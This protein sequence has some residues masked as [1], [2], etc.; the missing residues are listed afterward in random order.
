MCLGSGKSF[1]DFYR[2]ADWNLTVPLHMVELVAVL[3]LPAAGSPG[4]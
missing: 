1:N 2:Y 3:A 4:R